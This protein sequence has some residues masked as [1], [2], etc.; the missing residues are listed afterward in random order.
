M[1]KTESKN[2]ERDLQQ[3]IKDSAKRAAY[4]REHNIKEDLTSVAI[5]VP[6]QVPGGY[7]GV[8]PHVTRHP[9]NH[10]NRKSTKYEEALHEEYGGVAAGSVGNISESSKAKFTPGKN[11]FA[12]SRKS[13]AGSQYDAEP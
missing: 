10:M 4:N 12:R 2:I 6:T 13:A 3:Q 7:K 5:N 9:M 1:I 11:N 8:V